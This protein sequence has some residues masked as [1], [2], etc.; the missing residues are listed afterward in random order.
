MPVS[1]TANPTLH[2]VDAAH[3]R[4]R[5]EVARGGVGR[6]VAAHDVRLDR[7]VALKMLHDPKS[8]SSRFMREALLTARLQHP[9]IIP[10]HEIGLFPTGEPFIAMKLVRGQSLRQAIRAAKTLEERLQLLPN[11]LAV[12]DAIAYAHSQRVIHRDLKPSNVLLGAF[13]E[14]VVIDWGLAKH[15]DE[16]DI[17]TT[18][19]AAAS[20][21]VDATRTGAVLGTPA[22][23]SPE[24][25]CGDEVDERADV[26]ALGAILYELFSGAPP[27]EATSSTQVLALARRGA[28]P[29]LA[30]RVPNVPV[31]LATIIKR[32]MA[33]RIAERY[34]DAGQLAADL[35]RYHVGQVVAVGRDRGDDPP[36]RIK[37]TPF[38]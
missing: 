30:E 31:E 27:F 6:I 32:A 16:A 24:Q 19:D 1:A 34:R 22:Y 38:S 25:A 5:E 18:S 29:S 20:P 9:S 8:D 37:M 4:L 14:T 35:R 23:M 21:V 26:F 10:V 12:T 15:L 33:L 17:A 36:S 13:G 3:Y 7:D 11:V 28:F 2:Q